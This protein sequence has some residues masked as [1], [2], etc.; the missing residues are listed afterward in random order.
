MSKAISFLLLVSLALVA[1]A[2]T[3]D[4]TQIWTLEKA[5]W[6]YVKANDLEKYRSLWHE[7]FLG[8][9]SSSS[10]PARKNHITDWITANTSK[11]VTLQ[12]YELEQVAVQVTGDNAAVHYRIKMNWSGPKPT[13]TKNETLR[14]HHTWLRSNGSW[15]ILAGMSAPV[16]SEGK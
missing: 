4:E 1:R 11:G 14:I 8:W 7:Q 13:D 6:E 9:P 5:Y 10:S 12:S 15:Q 3:N 16:N 2:A